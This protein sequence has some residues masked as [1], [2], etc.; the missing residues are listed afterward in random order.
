M[1]SCY[2]WFLDFNFLCSF[3]SSKFLHLTG[4]PS[5]TWI[6]AKMIMSTWKKTIFLVSISKN[7][8][9][10]GQFGIFW[11]H[12]TEIISVKNTNL[13]QL[14]IL[15]CPFRFFYR[16]LKMHKQNIFNKKIPYYSCS[17]E[18]CENASLLG[19]WPENGTKKAADTY[20]SPWYCC[21]AFLRWCSWGL[22]CWVIAIFVQICEG[23]ILTNLDF[24]EN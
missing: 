8:I 12:L 19:T 4:P 7:G 3:L 21:N 11:K 6:P 14:L 15:S 20:W 5:R 2:V 24:S 9:F 13:F 16:F 22:Q 18:I 17:F 10:Y 23:K 1:H